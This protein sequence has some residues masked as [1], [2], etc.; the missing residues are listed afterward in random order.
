MIHI[1]QLGLK[2][3]IGLSKDK[4][5]ILILAARDRKT[6]EEGFPDYDIK[7]IEEGPG[8]IIGS[9]AVVL[10]KVFYKKQVRPMFELNERHHFLSETENRRVF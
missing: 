7:E 10:G 9:Q 4:P 1:A 6:L 3:G 2:S 8:E 5:D